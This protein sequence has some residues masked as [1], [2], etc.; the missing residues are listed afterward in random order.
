VSESEQPE[1]EAAVES[2]GFHGEPEPVGR[3][4]TLLPGGRA[5]ATRCSRSQRRERLLELLFF[6]ARR[7]EYK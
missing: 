7:E 3:G 6:V 5:E 2:I 4:L 1:A